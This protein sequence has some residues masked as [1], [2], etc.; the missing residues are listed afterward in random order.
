MITAEKALLSGEVYISIDALRRNAKLYRV[1]LGEEV[2][3]VLI[4]GTLHL[5]GY[6]DKDDKSRDKMFRKQELLV[7]RFEKKKENGF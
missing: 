3:R 1:S 6:L 2:I 7:K 5:C 4:H